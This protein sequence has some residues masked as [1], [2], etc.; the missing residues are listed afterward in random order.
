[1]MS[2]STHPLDLAPPK[3]VESLVISTL[4]LDAFKRGVVLALPEMLIC[5]RESGS[6]ETGV[7]FP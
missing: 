5:R 7:A 1:M 6:M 3:R 2:K 4:L